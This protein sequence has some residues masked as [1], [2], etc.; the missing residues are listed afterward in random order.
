MS[1][2]K[3]KRSLYPLHLVIGFGIMALFWLMPPIDPITPLGMRCVGSFLAMVYLWSA[4]DTL[5]PSMVGLFTLAISGYGGDGGFNGVWMVAVGTNTVL[6]TMFA[7]ILF[8]AMDAIGDTK[9]ITKWFLTRKIFKGRPITFLAVYF[10]LCFVL[11]SVCSP[12][13]SLILLWPISLTLL[14][15]LGITKED[16]VWPYFFVGMFGVSTLAQ[17]LF[18]F[19]G[20][21]LIPYSAFQSMTAAM[22]NPMSIPM[23]PYIITC[24][25]VTTIFAAIYL[26][27][28]R[29]ILRVD[30]SKFKAIDPQMLEQQIQLPPMNFA[31]KAYLIM[32]PLYLLISSCQALSRATRSATR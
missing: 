27:T 25:V 16:R 23:V 7:M 13:T 12:I 11:A 28:L 15:T 30:L 2:A 24:L 17:P 26:F 19:K 9:Y 31:Q 6:L 22:G 18:P 1:V 20:A 14:D 3:K 10:A 4:C 32:V 29:F 5:W 8:G 21:E